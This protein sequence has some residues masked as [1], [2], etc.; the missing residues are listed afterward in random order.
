MADS[1]FCANYNLKLS[2]S[3]QLIVLLLTLCGQVLRFYLDWSQAGTN[4][5]WHKKI[6]SNRVSYFSFFCVLFIRLVDALLHLHLEIKNS[7]NGQPKYKS[8]IRLMINHSSAKCQ[9]CYTRT[10]DGIIIKLP[11]VTKLS[12]NVHKLIIRTQESNTALL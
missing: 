4:I 12:N 1:M 8:R 2:N 7:A 10:T 6:Q 3:K 5:N 9:F 11:K